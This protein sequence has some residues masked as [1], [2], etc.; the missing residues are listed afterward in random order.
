M[1]KNRFSHIAHKTVFFGNI[2]SQ[3]SSLFFVQKEKMKIYV[4]DVICDGASWTADK[5]RKE[6]LIFGRNEKRESVCV[7]LQDPFKPHLLIVAKDLGNSGMLISSAEEAVEGMNTEKKHTVIDGFSVVDMTPVIGFTN[8]RKDKVISLELHD[9]S[10]F[11]QVMRAIQENDNCFGSIEVDI[12]HTKEKPVN[13]FLHHSHIRFGAWINVEDFRNAPQGKIDADIKITTKLSSIST[14]GF[15]AP[16]LTNPFRVMA[17]RCRA[18][19]SL[20]TTTSTYLPDAKVPGDSIRAISYLCYTLGVESKEDGAA[21][22]LENDEEAVLL[23]T[24][25]KAVKLEDPDVL[26]Q[27][28]DDINDIFYIAQRGNMLLVNTSLSRVK[29]QMPREIMYP[30]RNPNESPYLGDVAHPGRL[31]L[32]LQPVLK[33][34]M[35]SPPLDN[36]TL[37]GAVAHEKLVKNRANYTDLDTIN[38]LNQ[39]ADLKGDLEK[40]L[41]LI[42]ELERDN[43]F[44]SGAMALSNSC[45]ID[46]KSIAERGQQA[47]VYAVFLERFHKEKLYINDSILRKNFVVVKR[48]RADS[49]YPDPIFAPNPTREAFLT[50]KREDEKEKAPTPKKRTYEGFGCL[51]PYAPPKRAEKKKSTK[52]F[53][54]G[55]VIA[56]E[57]GFYSD[58]REAVFTFD[59]ASLYPS[60]IEGSRVCY[61]RVVYDRE[62]LED[63]KCKFEYIPLDDDTCAV[64]IVKYDGEP[65]CSI[66][67][68]I[69]SEVVQNRKRVRAMMKGVTDKFLLGSLNARQ[70]SCKVLQNA[71][72]GFLGSKTS[73]MTCLALAAAVCI[74]GQYQNKVMLAAGLARGYRKIYGDTDSC[75]LAIPA[76]PELTTRDEILKYTYEKAHEFEHEMTAL[77]PK[78][79]AVEFEVCK[80]PFLMTTKKKNYAALEWKPD[81]K[82]GYKSLIGKTVKALGHTKRDRCKHTF[83]TGDVL[84]TM[85]LENKTDV[86]QAALEWLQ[87]QVDYILDTSKHDYSRFVVTCNVSDTYKHEELIQCKVMDTMQQELGFRPLPGRRISYMVVENSTSDKHKDHGYPWVVYKKR[88][89]QSLPTPKINRAYYLQVQLLKPI[90]AILEHHPDIREPFKIMVAAA[91]QQIYNQKNKLQTVQSMFKKQKTSA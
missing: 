88:K 33:K 46:L 85:I 34:H 86:T 60:I 31:R 75:M 5:W 8:G 2:I 23:E 91:L 25:G 35:I 41:Q 80:L 70:L 47:R 43:E 54:G 22:F 9:T 72:Y 16:T 63:P 44:I 59:F 90:C 50:G 26:L 73:G 13:Q 17:I 83:L 51:K 12:L 48:L 3:K 1:K 38:F 45:G 69:V 64:F 49:T 79:N 52:A 84:I 57:A 32:D 14:R 21:V 74:I 11:Y 19:S 62:W 29:L 28:S 87:K 81:L 77:Y 7:A 27:C 78:P 58:P 4:S 30:S 66:V 76:P 65:V 89:A 53:A 36:F 61:M 24:F 55:F 67:D 68:K 39:N 71:L 37:E 40:Q 20:S 42:C 18:F 6:T 56:P 10:C 15:E 82:D